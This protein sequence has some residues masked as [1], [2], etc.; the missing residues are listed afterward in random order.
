MKAPL[1]RTTGLAHQESTDLRKCEIFSNP[2]GEGGSRFNFI[3]ETVI[4]FYSVAL[5]LT[6]ADQVAVP[7]P[8]VKPAGL[9]QRGGGVTGQYVYWITMPNALPETVASCG[10]KKL[11]TPYKKLGSKPSAFCLAPPGSRGRPDLQKPG[12]PVF[13]AHPLAS[14]TPLSRQMTANTYSGQVVVVVSHQQLFHSLTPFYRILC[15]Y[16]GK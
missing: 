13:S 7:A 10:V 5:W 11:G 9:L 6:M 12:F 8:A 14:P 2:N 3:H 4:E 15:F 1:A 16:I